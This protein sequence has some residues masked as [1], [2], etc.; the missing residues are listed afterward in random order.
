[1]RPNNGRK[2]LYVCKLL[3][4]ASFPKEAIRSVKGFIDGAAA[5]TVM[6]GLA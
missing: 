2:E 6:F 1:M 3:R 4:R 5:S